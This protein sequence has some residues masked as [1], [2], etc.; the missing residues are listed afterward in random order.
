MADP[1]HEIEFRRPLCITLEG[2]SKRAVPLLQVRK[3]SRFHARVVPY[4]KGAAE[5]ADIYFEGGAVAREVAFAF[6]SF[7]DDPAA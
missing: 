4:H 1:V 6:F 7:V 2:R 5:F 3:G